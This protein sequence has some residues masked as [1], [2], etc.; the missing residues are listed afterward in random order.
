V[1]A[2]LFLHQVR[3][4]PPPASQSAAAAVRTPALSRAV[5]AGQAQRGAPVGTDPLQADGGERQPA[6]LGL[7]WTA[8][9]ATLALLRAPAQLPESATAGPGRPTGTARPAGEAA[10][11]RVRRLHNDSQHSQQVEKVL[12][13]RLLPEVHWKA[14]PSDR[15]LSMLL[16]H[17]QQLQRP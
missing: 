3:W 16:S 4:V 1:V 13:L 6:R 10:S 9:C 17:L 2:L 11:R 15:Y 5:A 12:P 8:R 7:L 14:V